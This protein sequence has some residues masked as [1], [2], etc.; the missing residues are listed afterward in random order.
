MGKIS[1]E[2]IVL[3][4]I[5]IVDLFLTIYLVQ[6]REASEG[7]PLMAYYLGRG[8]PA[9]IAAKFVLCAVP[10]FILEYARRH[11]PRLVTYC[12][13]GVIAAY[14][15]SYCAGV[16]QMNDLR[17]Q[18]QTKNVDMAWINAPA[19]QYAA[20]EARRRALRSSTE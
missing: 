17:L 2:G 10:L 12:M 18:A 16:A 1:K 11:R 4:L 19:P 15:F 13:R 6:Y 7:N 5:G 20:F 3:I 9:F 8:I 14:M